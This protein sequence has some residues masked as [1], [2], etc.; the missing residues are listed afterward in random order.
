MATH[1]SILAW[2]IPWPEDPSRLQ[3]MGSQSRTRLSDFTHSLTRDLEL[4]PN[5]RS[6]GQYH[7]LVRL[8]TLRRANVQSP[9]SEIRNTKSLPGPSRRHMLRGRG[10]TLGAPAEFPPGGRAPPTRSSWRGRT[11]NPRGRR[12]RFDGEKATVLR[13]F[14]PSCL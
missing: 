13:R 3:F 7:F 8:F 10:M 9:V 14:R 2:K 11:G 4:V 1:S 12:L 6:P 5:S